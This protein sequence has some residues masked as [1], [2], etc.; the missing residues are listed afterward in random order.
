MTQL[1]VLD[2][3]SFKLSAF[4]SQQSAFS[5][6]KLTADCSLHNKGPNYNLLGPISRRQATQ[7]NRTL[8]LALT[9]RLLF[10]L[11]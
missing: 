9:K 11:S 2:P 3:S 10:R 5:G 7:G 1:L 4:S 6:Y 8:N